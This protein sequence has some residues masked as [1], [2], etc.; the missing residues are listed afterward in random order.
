MQKLCL[1]AGAAAGVQ[2]G[3]AAGVPAD[4][5]GGVQP[6]AARAVR[7]R[8]AAGGAPGVRADTAPGLPA[9]AQGGLRAG[10]QA[11]N[12][13]TQGCYSETGLHIRMGRNFV[14]LWRRHNC[15][16]QVT[17]LSPFCADLLINDINY[18]GC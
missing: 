2:Q 6:G 14:C 9:G 13:Y 3:G 5:P 1:C 15:R 10:R 17:D 8:A 18:W 11:G 4:P 7:Q 12:I 16:S